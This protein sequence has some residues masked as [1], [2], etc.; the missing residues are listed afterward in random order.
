MFRIRVD[1]IRL[2]GGAAVFVAAV[3]LLV[4]CAPAKPAAHRELTQRQR[5]STLGKS[6]LPGAFTVTKALEASDRASTR[7]ADLDRQASSD[8]D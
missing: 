3:L 1:P 5:D 8:G 4:S 7:S 6:V 2:T